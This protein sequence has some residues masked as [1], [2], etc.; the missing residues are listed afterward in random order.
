[1]GS[2]VGL[3]LVCKTW[4]PE[5]EST[6]VQVLLVQRSIAH[7]DNVYFITTV[8][9]DLHCVNEPLSHIYHHHPFSYNAQTGV[10]YRKGGCGIVIVV[11]GSNVT[12]KVTVI[13]NMNVCFRE[14][15]FSFL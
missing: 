13:I 14:I 6:G 9:N 4:G 15:T 11:D 1:V 3:S 2:S 12:V 10:A 5:F 8:L 7:D